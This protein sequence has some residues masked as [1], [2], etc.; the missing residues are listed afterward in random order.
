MFDRRSRYRRSALQ[1]TVKIYLIPRRLSRD[2]IYLFGLGE[3]GVREGAQGL[4]VFQRD[5]S[6]RR[7]TSWRNAIQ[8]RIHSPAG[9][10][11]R[12][13]APGRTVGPTRSAARLR[14]IVES[15][16]AQSLAP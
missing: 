11:V 7:R 15:V 14:G 16:N 1:M 8:A 3:G 5:P 13:A 2:T 4:F 10:C 12:G 9:W 6:P